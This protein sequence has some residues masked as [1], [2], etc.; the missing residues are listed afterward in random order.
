M[1]LSSHVLEHQNS[2]YIQS[3]KETKKLYRQNPQLNKTQYFP[4]EDVHVPYDFIN[5]FTHRDKGITHGWRGKR[6]TLEKQLKQISKVSPKSVAPYPPGY[7][8]PDLVQ[9]A[10]TRNPFDRLHA[11]WSDKYRLESAFFRIG[12]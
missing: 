5:R 4:P 9:V 10:N 8:H 1:T 7:I 11:A 2:P 6:S 3:W 12:L